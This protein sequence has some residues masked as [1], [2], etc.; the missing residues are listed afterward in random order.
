MTN[1]TDSQKS[2][3]TGG[4]EELI[5][6]VKIAFGAVVILGLIGLYWGLSEAGL[7]ATLI[8]EQALRDWVDR[9]GAWGPLVIV[10]LMMVAIVMS[11][12]PSGPIAMAASA[13]YGPLWGTLYVVLGAEGGAL[14]AFWLARCSATRLFDDGRVCGRCCGGSIS[15]DRKRG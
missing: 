9:L 4:G 13:A 10:V 2:S 3:E 1:S 14:I 7:L 5:F 8:D 11:P 15:A 12:I 6:P